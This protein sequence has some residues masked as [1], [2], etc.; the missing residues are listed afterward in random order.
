MDVLF[1]EAEE[2]I[3]QSAREFLQVESPVKLVRAIEGDPGTGY[4]KDLWSKIAGLGWVGLALPEQYGG[5][6][7]GLPFLGIV[8]EELGRAIAPV[9]FVTTAAPALVLAA[10]G[11]DDLRRA[12]LPGISEGKTILTWAF[13]E[14]DPRLVPE[15]VQLWAAEDGDAFVLNGTKLF[16]EYF[17]DAQHCLVA[18]R[19]KPGTGE[20]GVS[21]LLVDTRSTGISATPI[22]NIANDPL[23]E[24]T[25]SNVRVPRGN[26]VGSL[27]G[28]WPATEA[29]LQRATALLC[30]QMSGA[31]RKASELAFEYAKHRVAFGKPIGAF[32]VIAHMCA[33][34]LIAVDGCELLTYEA[35]WRL[36]QGLPA[37]TEV[38]Q[39][40]AFCSEKCLAVTR[41]ANIVHGGLAFT[42]ELDLNLWF[43]RTSAWATRL[44]TSFEHR[45]RVAAAIL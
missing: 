41:N 1:N 44:G 39:A 26:L 3:K 8:T 14:H 10:H 9:P 40:K 12:V 38:S 2:M 20:D 43:R 18:C 19:T 35:L 23:S 27:H 5:Q 24:V 42:W 7:L 15:A 30:A 4:A 31:A 16:V 11:S 25:F 36:D 13:T 34:M 22:P 6:G 21:L 17:N 33:D 37:G 45:R 29:L 32:Q 28:G